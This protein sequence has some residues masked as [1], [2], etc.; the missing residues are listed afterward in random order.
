MGAN[1][2]G[3]LEVVGMP[4]AVPLVD[5]LVVASTLV[6]PLAALAALVVSIA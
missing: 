3:M 4:L 5:P 2:T 6:D 1:L